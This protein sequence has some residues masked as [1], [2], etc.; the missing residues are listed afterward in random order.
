MKNLNRVKQVFPV[1]IIANVIC[2]YIEI[3]S[4][5]HLKYLALKKPYLFQNGNRTEIRL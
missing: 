5:L 3:K 4:A 1:V 2:C